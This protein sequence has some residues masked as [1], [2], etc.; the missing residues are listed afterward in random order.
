VAR[1]R[2]YYGN[3]DLTIDWILYSGARQVEIRVTL[4]WHEK[5]KMLKFSFLVNVESPVATWETS[6]G[7][8]ERNPT[9]DEEPGQRW[10]DVT[11]RVNGGTAGL[12]VI[13][14]AKYGYSIKGADMR[15]SVIRSAVFAH[16]NPRVLDMNAE[17]IWQDQGIH[18]F[19]MLVAPHQ[20]SWKE[21]GIV[22]LAEE[23]LSPPVSIYQGIHGG[24]LPKSGSY[25]A[26]DSS[27]VIVTSVKQAE[28]DEDIILRC[29]E[30]H[31]TDCTATIDIRFAGLKWSGSF[32]P[33]E[34]K[35]LRLH[36]ATGEIREVN[37]LEE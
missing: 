17:H 4:N 12:S 16:H 8:I 36:K 35:S 26:A 21:S 9:G 33:C 2:S 3:S 6:Y 5:L 1:V 28:T 25:L 14:D 15:V 19:R 30:T 22:R 27:S 32:K 23:F 18:T 7:F 29:V 31:G 20:G 34:I 37:L 10:I 11:G 13:N 24:R